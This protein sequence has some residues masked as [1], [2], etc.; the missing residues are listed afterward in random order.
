MVPE[1]Q[2]LYKELLAIVMLVK[3]FCAYWYGRK[4]SIRTDHASL[5]CIKWLRNPDDQFARWIKRLETNCICAV[6]LKLELTGYYQDDNV[7][8]AELDKAYVRHNTAIPTS[9]A[10]D[11]QPAGLAGAIATNASQLNASASAANTP[12][13]SAGALEQNAPEGTSTLPSMFGCIA[14]LNTP[15]GSTGAL[16]D[17]MMPYN[18][19]KLRKSITSFSREL[20]QSVRMTYQIAR[21]HTHRAATAQKKYYDRTAHLK[22]YKVGDTVQLKVFRKEKGVG[23][24]A[25]RFE[26]PYYILDVLSDVNFRIIRAMEDKPKVV[27]HDHIIPY[28]EREPEPASDKA[29]VF[30]RSRTYRPPPIDAAAQTDVSAA[31]E[32]DSSAVAIPGNFCMAIDPTN[33]VTMTSESTHQEHGDVNSANIENMDASACAAETH[34]VSGD[35]TEVTYKRR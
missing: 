33:D 14:P 5:K 8:Q 6:V 26:G 3:H 18:P 10:E 25:D 21:E 32:D 28:M 4:C 24:F 17:V 20:D 1:D 13:G 11:V 35:V 30:K 7:T 15:A 12:T 31:Q 22:R 19:N 29:W 34:D 9:D 2:A 16:V 23:K 27:H